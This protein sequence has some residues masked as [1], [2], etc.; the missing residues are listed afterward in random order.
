M[1][2]SLP[3]GHWTGFQWFVRAF[4]PDDLPSFRL[5]FFIFFY[6]KWSHSRNNHFIAVSPPNR[7]SI[8][9]KEPWEADDSLSFFCSKRLPGV[10]LHMV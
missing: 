6:K 7:D 3:S 4:E 9:R 10:E 2:N 5:F 1:T 8:K